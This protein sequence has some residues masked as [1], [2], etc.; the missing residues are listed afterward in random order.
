M[1]CPLCSAPAD[2]IDQSRNRDFYH[3]PVCRYIFVPAEQHLDSRSER[4]RYL[5][6]NNS[7]ENAGYVRMF[8]EKL[9]LVAEHG[10][11]GGSALDFG[12]GYEPV[13]KTLLEKRG[14]TASIYD[15]YFFPEWREEWETGRRF[16]W[17]I[18]TETFEHLESPAKGLDRILRAIRPGGHLAIMTQFYPEKNG[19]YDAPAFANWY[20]RNDPTHIG[21]FG[22]ATFEWLARTRGLNLIFQNNRDFVLFRTEGDF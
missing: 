6:H 12:C 21:F 5:E 13:L 20:Y 3:C 2:W 4:E 18:S 14:Y 17:I 10:P 16:D 7:L 15:P 9:D 11:V 8:E 22:R 19:E 1:T